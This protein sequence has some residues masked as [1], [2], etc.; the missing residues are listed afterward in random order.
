MYKIVLYN[1]GN[2]VCLMET[3]K[4]YSDAV[5]KY[6]QLIKENQVIFEK[7]YM[8]D[9]VKADYELALTAK[10]KTKHITH[11]RDEN[12]RIINIETKGNFIIKKLTP[13]KKEET[14]THR[15]TGEKYT[16]KEFAKIF[17]S[18]KLTN[19]VTTLNNKLAIEYFENDEVNLFVLK[20][21]SDSIRLNK[22]IKTFAQTNGLT[23]FVFFT[24]PNKK[25]TSALFD[26]IVKKIGVK[27][28]YLKKVSTR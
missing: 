23:N 2:R 5:D 16:F 14:I 7:K 1:S 27:R 11:T 4:S 18:N 22:L 20:K 15:N 8:W 28:H 6:N 21:T 12:G 17:L 24:N 3:F 13:Y 10:N 19:I 9:G 25:N 26:K